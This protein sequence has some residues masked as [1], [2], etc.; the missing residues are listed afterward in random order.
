MKNDGCKTSSCSSLCGLLLQRCFENWRY[1]NSVVNIKS[2]RKLALCFC[3]IFSLTIIVLTLPSDGR[4]GI[5]NRELPGTTVLYR[6]DLLFK[7]VDNLGKNMALTENSVITSATADDQR[8]TFREIEAAQSKDFSSDRLSGAPPTSKAKGRIQEH[9]QSEALVELWARPVGD[10]LEPCP[11][12]HRR[13]KRSQEETNGYLMINANGGLNQMRNGIC[14][15]VAIARIMNATLVV[16]SLD[17]HSFWADPSEFQDIFD[18]NHFIQTLQADVPI[19]EAL[20]A[21]VANIVPFWKAPVSWSKRSYYK[22]EIVPLLKTH[23]VVYFSHTDS[24]LTNNDLPDSVQRLRCRSCY[25]G[26]K[27]TDP[28][29][30][31]GAKLV[32]RM[33]VDNHYIALHLRYEKDMLAFTGCV[34]GLSDGEAEELQQMRYDVK[35]WK[36]KDIEGEGKRQEGGC[37]LT[38]KET[39]LLLKGLGFPESTRIYIVAGEIYGNGSVETLRQEFPN[40]FSH[41]N[42][43]TE[44]E[45]LPFKNYQNRLAALDY[46]VALESDVFVYTYD[47]NMA[48]A[49]Q[50]HRRFEGYRKTISP[51]RKNLVRL[52]DELEAGKIPWKRFQKQVQRLHKNKMG[53]PEWRER[54][55]SPKS[56]ENFYANPFPGCI[57]EKKTPSKITTS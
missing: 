12:N 47:G 9:L 17:H 3:A 2:L 1:S 42:L 46:I 5:H 15:M 16:P 27:F 19:V 39:A 44:E 40:V 20:P 26:L 30:Q 43:A 35:H 36:E 14:D 29:Q 45:L 34:H 56:E 25:R 23:R 32:D 4:S 31:L 52:V 10:S 54:G 53:G 18:V 55:D 22:N 33:R 50:G 38:P 48:K 24:R 11:D 7:T 13:R 41:S 51:E 49:V 28:I 21:P 8:E 37:P 6:Q 57:C